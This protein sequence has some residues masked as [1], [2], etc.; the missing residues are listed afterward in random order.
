[1]H[2]I[3]IPDKQ[4]Y[5]Y[6]PTCL[7][8]CRGQQ[9]IEVAGLMYKYI[10]G[11]LYYE[12]FRVHMVYKLLNM[13]PKNIG[14][15]SPIKTEN[16]Y[17]LSELIDTFFT[18]TPDGQKT[19]QLSIWQNPIPVYKPMFKKYYGP[20]DGFANLTWG[21]Y[22]DALR[23]YHDYAAEQDPEL[24]YI[25]AAMFYSPNKVYNPVRVDALAKKFKKYP[26]GFAYG[27]YLFFASFNEYL[28]T[29][30]VPWAGKTIDVS[31][32]FDGK[33]TQ[34]LYPS[35]GMDSI[36]FAM[37]ESGTFGNLEEL[38]KTNFWVVLMRLYDLRKKELEEKSKQKKT[39]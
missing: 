9:Y 30:Q 24:L 4:K 27:V 11:Q 18:D 39:K 8:E 25:L 3:F 12:E 14:K 31:I 37:A 33:Q 29:A 35:I 1:M 38:N 28:A 16:V 23:V 34:E 20:A 10:S 36:A 32:L 22:V 6:L 21:Q 26:A 13:K 15:E 5:L 2:Q 19:I 17:R 7:A